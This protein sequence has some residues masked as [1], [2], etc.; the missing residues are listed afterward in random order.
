MSDRLSEQIHFLRTPEAAALLRISPR[1]L[2]KHRSRGSGP[3][4]RRAGGTVLYTRHDLEA[5][6]LLP[7]SSDPSSL[8]R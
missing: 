1:T 4:F 3:A 8:L 6:T 7:E 5:W 2:E